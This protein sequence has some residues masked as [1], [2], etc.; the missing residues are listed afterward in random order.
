MAKMRNDPQALADQK[1]IDRYNNDPMLY[2]T[3]AW[4]PFLLMA[5]GVVGGFYLVVQGI[6]WIFHMPLPPMTFFWN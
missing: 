4:L 6:A 5:L 3:L 1:E 2:D